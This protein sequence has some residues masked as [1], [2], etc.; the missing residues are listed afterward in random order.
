MLRP[1]AIMDQGVENRQPDVLASPKRMQSEQSQSNEKLLLSGPN[2]ESVDFN[3]DSPPL[4][5]NWTGCSSKAF[6]RKSDLR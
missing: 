4:R 6:T 3:T 2:L 1:T 5:C